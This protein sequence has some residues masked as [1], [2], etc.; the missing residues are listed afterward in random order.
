MFSYKEAS[1]KR[2]DMNK[3]A[4]ILFFLNIHTLSYASFLDNPLDDNKKY[5]TSA[6]APL[7]QKEGYLD[8][9]STIT[10]SHLSALDQASFGAVSKD[11][12]DMVNLFRLRR[13]TH[14]LIQIG[15][16]TPTLQRLFQENVF[17]GWRA[18]AQTEK[19][20]STDC[21]HR[22]FRFLS[23]IMEA[24]YYNVPLVPFLTKSNNT[25]VSLEGI[26]PTFSEPQM[27]DFRSFCGK[28][29]Y[30]N[31]ILKVQHLHHF[32]R[33][34]EMFCLFSTHL[35]D[36]DVKHLIC[37]QMDLLLSFEPNLLADRLKEASQ[38]E[39]TLFAIPM[40]FETKRAVIK[41]CLTSPIQDVLARITNMQQVMS[42][43][44][45]R[46]LTDWEE[47][48][49][50]CAYIA[51]K[52]DVFRTRL[53]AFRDFGSAFFSQSSMFIERKIIN[54]QD[55]ASIMTLCLTLPP[56]KTKLLSENAPVF[57]PRKTHSIH[58]RPSLLRALSYMNEQ[59][60][61]ILVAHAQNF[62]FL[63][64]DAHDLIYFLED[65]Q[66]FSINQLGAVGLYAHT[67]F[68]THMDLVSRINRVKFLKNFTP[69]QI[70][71]LGEKESIK[72]ANKPEPHSL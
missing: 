43:I 53:Q 28:S 1:P 36:V 54:Q 65:M 32:N 58:D 66:Y 3:K 50:R 41:A 69:T 70:R 48:A 34:K 42:T 38:H 4:L 20:K 24:A 26:L 59:Q 6:L 22:Q 63:T 55:R 71:H 56:E 72:L 13:A 25:L 17:E 35:R 9:I 46:G 45:P 29:R 62:S 60:I 33:F 61:R 23:S 7:F 11:I 14:K 18:R 47:T 57:F 12:C 68:P 37:Q 30:S 5:P 49:W 39:D 44:F 31:D 10:M 27:L 40:N 15:E 16:N 8:S 19:E 21:Y 64:I 2:S 52:K 67:F 51:L